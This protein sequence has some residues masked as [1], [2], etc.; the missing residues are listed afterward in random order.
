MD[1]KRQ[2]GDRATF[3]IEEICQRH[4]ISRQTVY[5]EIAQGRL[6]TFKIGRRRKVTKEAEQEWIALLEQK[7]GGRP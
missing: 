7:S 1:R 2:K 4:N 5:R 6:R 3:D